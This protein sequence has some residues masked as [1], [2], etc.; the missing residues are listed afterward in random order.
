M[1]DEHEMLFRDDELMIKVKLVVIIRVQI[2][3][4]RL[5]Y[6]ITVFSV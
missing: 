6:M 5:H 3:M 1:C 2:V 4:A